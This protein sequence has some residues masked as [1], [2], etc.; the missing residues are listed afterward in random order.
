MA[1]NTSY[2][3]LGSSGSVLDLIANLHPYLFDCYVEDIQELGGKLPD[4]I[5]T[6]RQ[7][8]VDR[9]AKRK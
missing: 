6:L 9:G 5:D 4:N 7:Q 3:W 1:D 2:F 8:C